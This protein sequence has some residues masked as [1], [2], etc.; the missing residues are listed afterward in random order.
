MKTQLRKLVLFGGI[1]LGVLLIVGAVEAGEGCPAIGVE[2]R[3]ALVFMES[4]GV[5][6]E[7]EN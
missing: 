4:S 2:Q 6:G 7:M 1:N 3:P 5:H